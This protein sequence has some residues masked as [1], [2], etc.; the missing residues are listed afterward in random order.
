ML[1]VYL[2]NLVFHPYGQMVKW[3]NGQMVKWSNG[4]MVKWSNGHMVK[5]SYGHMVFGL[6]YSVV[7]R[8]IYQVSTNAMIQVQNKKRQK[9]P[10]TV[11]ESTNC[12]T[13]QPMAKLANVTLLIYISYTPWFIWEYFIFV[14]SNLFRLHLS[15]LESD[16]MQLYN[17]LYK[18][19]HFS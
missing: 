18:S 19:C 16:C 6:G 5:W 4:Q 12:R 9:L 11:K 7:Q 8:K 10:D 3:L 17:C 15:S 13:Y 14:T 2:L 1:L